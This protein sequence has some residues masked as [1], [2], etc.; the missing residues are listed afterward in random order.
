ML[1]FP[2][3]K[4]FFLKSGFLLKNK[5]VRILYNYLCY[6][7]S[8]NIFVKSTKFDSHRNCSLCWQLPSVKIYVIKIQDNGFLGKKKIFLNNFPK[9]KK[10]CNNDRYY[11]NTSKSTA[12]K[13]IDCCSIF[14]CLNF[15]SKKCFLGDAYVN[16]QIK[17]KKNVKKL[18]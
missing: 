10:M 14:R 6:F 7:K 17:K 11:L 18:I 12:I 16:L 2:K 8:Y 4:M 5:S 3:Q 9:I 1:K 13:M 15:H